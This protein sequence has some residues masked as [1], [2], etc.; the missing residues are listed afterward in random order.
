V[1]LNP[2][3]SVPLTRLKTYGA[4]PLLAV[5]VCVY[6]A[7]RLHRVG[8]GAET[9]IRISHADGRRGGVRIRGDASDG[10]TGAQA[11]ANGQRATLQRPGIGSG[12]TA[13]GEVLRVVRADEEV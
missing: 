3:G 5:K 8:H 1:K 11:Q 4:L 9:A 7:A 12:A 2:G 6:R 13:G 10:S